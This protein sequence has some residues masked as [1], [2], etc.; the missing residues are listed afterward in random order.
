MK[1]ILVIH[2]GEGGEIATYS[3]MGHDLSVQRAGC[4]G[5]AERAR[6]LIQAYDDQVDAIALDG[7]PAT[8]ELGGAQR[9]HELG[10][11]LPA[12]AQRAAVVDG[13]GIRAG[14]ERWG[15]ILAD[16]AQ[17]GIFAQKR[18]LM[19]PGLN[20][21]GLAGA[22]GRRAA[23]LRYADPIVYF[24]LPAWPLV[25]SRGTLDQAA[26]PTLDQ[27]RDAAFDRLYPLPGG[28]AEPRDAAAF[29]WADILAGDI[30]AI[31]R[32][33]PAELKRK[34]VVVEWATE[35]D[36]ADL[37]AR[38]VN[39]VVTM[40]P[41]LDGRGELGRW[42]A[43]VI[44]AIMAALRPDP[45]APLSEDTYLD[46]M[47]NL[48]WTPA[49]RYL[50]PGE[51]GINRF[52]FV[53]HP[54]SIKFIHNDKRFRWT[55]VLPDGLVES[56]S[57]LIPPMYLSRITGGVSPTT[58]QRIEG[59]LISLGATPRQMMTRG[60]RFTYDKL[61]KAARIAERKG[62][63]IMGLGAFTSVVGDAGITVAHEAD[64]AITSGNSLTVAATLEAAKQAVVKMGATDLTKGKVM[65]IG[66]TGSI[67]SVCARLLAQAIY[68]VVLVS[69]EPERLIELKRTIHE[70]T[71]GA[72]VAIATKADDYLSQ[73]DLIVTATSAFGQRIVDITK[74]KPGAVICD[75]ARPPD[76]S[77]EEAALR[78]DVLVIESG[79]VLI[80]GEIDF[81]YNIGL[82]PGTAYACL[83]ETALLAMEGRFEDYTLGRNI[84]MERVKE[85]YRLFKKHDFQIAGL[86][87]HDEYVTDEMVAEKRVLADELR[88]DAARFARVQSE[89]AA[90]LATIP[91]SSK[92]VKAGRSGVW[93]PVAAVGAAAAAGAAG[94]LLFRRRK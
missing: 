75:V 49:V 23:D 33:A 77:E 65:I 31:R 57:A 17:P 13:N 74:C 3:F 54:L 66:A 30:G 68:D 92:G 69:I 2:A 88:R 25:G 86:R 26:G 55:K 40:M 82:P 1:K 5:D 16:R 42:P 64:I 32:H 94:L 45:A 84:T 56:F 14:L 50:Q 12:V 90:K 46:L 89:S 21:N 27:L 76:I 19:V 10:A 44:E 61:N 58:G 60:E 9:T 38:G 78:P 29:E 24:N 63:R 34:T 39:I 59:H 48:D 73:C 43:A 28:P 67:G 62:A 85:I 52:A 41:A 79:E 35:E 53:I 91:V 87:S 20:H 4:G 8:L 11:T 18:V 71:P 83:A 70:E 80:P 47:A 51:A 37:R 15:V 93:R 7:M 72:R 81:G 36:L 6:A 22:L